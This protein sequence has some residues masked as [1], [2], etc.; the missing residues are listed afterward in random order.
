MYEISSYI[1]I[2]SL[3]SQIENAKGFLFR[4]NPNSKHLYRMKG[5]KTTAV[6]KQKISKYLRTKNP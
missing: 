1:D 3:V 5:V 2:G 6:Q 4:I